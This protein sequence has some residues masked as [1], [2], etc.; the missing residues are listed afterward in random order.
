MA[1]LPNPGG[2]AGNWGTILN[3]F[4]LVEHESDGTLRSDGTLADKA[5]TTHTHSQSDVT[6]LETALDGKA[7]A[8]HTHAQSDVTGLEAALDEKLDQATADGLYAELTHTHAQSEVTGLETAL[9]DRVTEAEVDALVQQALEDHTPGIELGYAERT[10]AYSAGNSDISGLSVTVTGQGRPVD[11]EFYCSTAYHSVTGS[12][13]RADIK[14]N[15]TIVNSWFDV[16]SSTAAGRT[17]KVKQRLVLTDGA[18]YTFT[19]GVFQGTAGT[20]TWFASAS[21]VRPMW[22]SVVSR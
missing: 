17:C 8:T 13:I 4:L 2:D 12:L 9:D 5:D 11:V 3:D 16:T 7:D 21:P 20:M 1:R 10:T 6:G 22:L 19:I 14:S 18:S 15:G